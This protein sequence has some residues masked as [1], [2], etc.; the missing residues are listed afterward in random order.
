MTHGANAFVYRFDHLYSNASI[1][2]SFGL[3]KICGGPA[4]CHASELP[5]VFGELPAFANF[6]P[7]EIALA[8]TMGAFWTSFAKTGN[9]NGGGGT[10]WP[11]WDTQTRMTLVLNDTLMTESTA[12]G[13]DV[14]CDFWDSLSGAYFW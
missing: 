2:P 5:F 7:A 9:P 11:A 12:D 8:D 13:N 6:T 3:P 4:V 1:F 10:T 14:D